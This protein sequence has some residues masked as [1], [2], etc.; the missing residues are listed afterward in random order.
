MLWRN[1]NAVIVGKNQD[2]LA[3]IDH[4]YAQAH[5]I[6]VHRRMTGG[7]AVYHDLGNVNFTLIQPG[8]GHF[9][10]YAYFTADL[11]A[12]LASLG[13]N[14]ALNDRNDILIGNR[15]F[16][17]NAQCVR[18]GRVL[19]HGCVLFDTD[20]SMLST[21]LRPKKGRGVA[22]VQSRVV[23]LREYINMNTDEFLE[24]FAAF[25]HHREYQFTAADIIEIQKLAD[26]KYN[27]WE[28]NFGAAPAWD[29]PISPA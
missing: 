6:R 26:E 8:D 15:K 2:T 14:A 4:D 7:G 5:G 18:G 22:S 9:N 3:E 19:H 20:L 12:F 28:W 13:V 24:A 27:T 25:L 17:G 10:D 11:I 23:N 1:K 21:V 29:G 16:C